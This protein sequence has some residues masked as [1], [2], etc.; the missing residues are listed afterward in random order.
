MELAS[1]VVTRDD[2]QQ[3]VE[4][5]EEHMVEAR[6]RAW[7]CLGWKVERQDGA[8]APAT[9]V[10]EHELHACRALLVGVAGLIV[11]MALGGLLAWLAR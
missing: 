3:F 6:C 7:R 1:L 2:G 8:P 4:T 9:T 11:G 5:C 10:L